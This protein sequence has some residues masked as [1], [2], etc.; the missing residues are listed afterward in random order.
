MR[1]LLK[2]DWYYIRTYGISYLPL[3]LLFCLCTGV[4]G[5][6]Y[7]MM[8]A[9]ALPRGAI[10]NDMRRWD[11]Y[12]VMLPCRTEQ[13]VGGK[14]LLCG[15]GVAIGA[16]V[17]ALSFPAQKS[18]ARALRRFGLGMVRTYFPWDVLSR[19]TALLEFV[20]IL[21]CLTV[22]VVALA[23]PV[24]Y[25]FGVGKGQLGVNILVMILLAYGATWS[26]FLLYRAPPAAK[27]AM[28]AA[29]VLLSAAGTLASFRLSVRFCRQRLRGAY[30]K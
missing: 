28:L 23:F 5:A 29:L 21:V 6:A 22:L 26:F 24:Y 8:L 17:S 7:A 9:L 14:Y 10:A 18:S 30:D 11:R 3:L 4:W 15:V 13:I 2:K 20:L 19:E 16:A 12:A 25:R 27:A 1:G